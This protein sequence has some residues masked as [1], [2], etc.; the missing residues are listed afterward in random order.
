M[1]QK[2]ISVLNSI[3]HDPTDNGIVSH[4]FMRKTFLQYANKH[5]EILEEDS[6]LTDD[7]YE[8]YMVK[9]NEL[10]DKHQSKNDYDGVYEKILILLQDMLYPDRFNFEMEEYATCRYIEYTEYRKMPKNNGNSRQIF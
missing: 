8:G 2:L 10:L 5:F 4:S 6:K 7:E 3:K 1:T 9:V